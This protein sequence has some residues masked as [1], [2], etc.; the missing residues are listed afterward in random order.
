M[1]AS[2][3]LLLFRNSLPPFHSPC[4]PLIEPLHLFPCKV[5]LCDVLCNPNRKPPACSLINLSPSS[6][7][8]LSLLNFSQRQDETP[9]EASVLLERSNSFEWLKHFSFYLSLLFHFKKGNIFYEW[10]RAREGCNFIVFRMEGKKERARKGRTRYPASNR[11]SCTLNQ[12]VR[13]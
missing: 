4:F 10:E 8:V 7:H 5:S 6:F 12:N 1:R 9:S 11:E 3:S 13:E 2:S